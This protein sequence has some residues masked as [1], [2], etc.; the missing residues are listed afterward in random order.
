MHEICKHLAIDIAVSV[1][2]PRADSLV[3]WVKLTERPTVAQ[4]SYKE[5]PNHFRGC[6]YKELL[7]EVISLSSLEMFKQR[8]DQYFLGVHMW[9]FL[10][11][12]E[13]WSNHL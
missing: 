8:L 1:C 4:Y 12:E 3:Q 10:Y 7:W 13:S 9:E 2:G 11:M 5:L 6:G